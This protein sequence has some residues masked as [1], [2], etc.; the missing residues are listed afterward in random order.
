[1]ISLG[2]RRPFPSPG[3]F[4]LLVVL[5]LTGVPGCRTAPPVPPRA[6]DASAFK[7]T[8]ILLSLDGWRWDYDRKVPVPNL[9][10]LI[11]RGVRA[12]R[13]IP[14][15]PTLTFPNHYSVVT[16]LYPEHHGV[17]GNSMFDPAMQEKFAL[18]DRKAVSDGRWWGGEPIWVTAERQGQIAA[19]MFWPGSEAEIHGR[20]PR[21][22]RVFDEDLP[23]R[24][25]VDQILDWLDLPVGRRPTMIVGYFGDVDHEGHEHGP[26]SPQVRRAMQRVDAALG[27]LLQGLERRALIDRVNIVVTSDHGMAA[28]RSDGAIILDDYLDA[29]TVQ[30]VDTGAT[31]GVNPKTLTV[32][33]IYARLAR[34]HPHLRV[35]RKADTPAAWHY[36]DHPRV[37][38]IVGQADE[39]WIVVRRP[40][41]GKRP[42]LA[43]GMHGYDP[44]LESMHGLLVAAGPAFRSGVVVPPV[45]NVQIYHAL[46]A[47]LGLTPAPNDGD[48]AASRAW[49][50]GEVQK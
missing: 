33:E 45:E 15:Y 11:A 25:R 36:R 27:R 40:K 3:L 13:L 35:F 23:N 43:K 18:R 34:A 1:M 28:V 7:P 17:V 47:A 29:D 31:F 9:Q 4:V 26:D 12:E 14:S 42:S 16:G 5:L 32:D 48:A 2:G 46:A 24:A 49:M 50:A 22:W 6:P 21:Y 20:R 41:N 8:V 37:P 10:R 30:I 19:A 38:A 44:A 39:G